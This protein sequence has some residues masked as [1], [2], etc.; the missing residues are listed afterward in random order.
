MGT[1]G[2]MTLPHYCSATSKDISSI[3]SLTFLL[4]VFN[5]FELGNT[6]GQR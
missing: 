2:D 1:A 4:L 6:R 3:S 5:V